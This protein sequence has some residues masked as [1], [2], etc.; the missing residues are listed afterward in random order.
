M[1]VRLAGWI[2]GAQSFRARGKSNG[3]NG[4]GKEIG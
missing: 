1:A 3:E 2:R 4:E